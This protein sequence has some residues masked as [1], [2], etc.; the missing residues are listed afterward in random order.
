MLECW[1][2]NVYVAVCVQPWSSAAAVQRHE[3]RFNVDIYYRR[4]LR[5]GKKFRRSK[6]EA[7]HSITITTIILLFIN[8]YI[9]MD[10]SSGASE[11]CCICAVLFTHQMAALF[12]VK[13]RHGRRLK[14]WRKVENRLRQSVRIYVTNIPAKLH[15]YP[16]LYDGVL[17][18]LKMM[19]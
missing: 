14:L 4:V 3:T 11:G 18:F 1:R 16:I 5:N 13:W 7:E 2:A 19:P 12:C 10:H 6:R 9:R 15:S 17:G 8:K